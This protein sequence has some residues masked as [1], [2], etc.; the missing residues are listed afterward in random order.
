MKNKASTLKRFLTFILLF[1]FACQLLSSCQ[2]DSFITSESA[3]LITSADTLKFDTVFTSIGSVTQTFKINNLNNQKLLL[4]QVK[5]MGGS[6]SPFS[7]NINGTANSL[8]NNIEIAANDSIYVF[9]TAKINPNSAPLPFIVKD[10]I[11][12]VYN[13]NSKFI[14]LEGYGQNANFL[15]NRNISGNITW[16]NNLPY[17]ILGSLTINAGSSLTIEA[18]CKIYSHANAPFLVNGTL[19]TYGTQALPIIFNGDRIDGNYKDLPAAWLGIYFTGTSSDNNMTHTI[20]KN[21][22]QAVVAEQP[23][24][25]TKPKL[26]LHQ[27]IIDNAMDVGLMSINSSIS[28]DNSLIT[29]CGNNLRLTYGGV[30]NFTNCTLVSFSTSFIGHTKPVL[31]INNSFI[32]GTSVQTSA[33]TANFTNCIIW[34]DGSLVDNEITID[35]QGTDSFNVLLDH[36]LYKANTDPANS[37][38]S[39]CIK[40]QMPLFDNIDYAKQIFNFKTNNSL[41]PGVDKGLNGTGFAK[42]LN[43]N[44]RTVNITDIGCYEKQ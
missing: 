6:S 41:A 13:G 11:G 40:N 23:S 27:C 30:Y 22:L 20:I 32:N 10:S 31:I 33:L 14:Q 12:I 16:P 17:V 4:Q 25:N 7:L 19:V 8:L 37:I 21:A 26:T 2:K 24:I 1:F 3:L 36:C 9:V 34:G 5:L 35:K 39:Q 43:D 38:I 15:R 42:D 29:N 44:N 28:A 18:G